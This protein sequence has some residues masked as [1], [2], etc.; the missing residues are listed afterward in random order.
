MLRRD[1]A[2][3]R[4]EVRIRIRSR[5]TRMR[6]RKPGMRAV[7][8]V[9]AEQDTPH[10]RAGSRYIGIEVVRKVGRR[11]CAYL[12]RHDVAVFAYHHALN[13]PLFSRQF[14]AHVVV[15]I[16]TVLELGRV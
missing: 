7:I 4:A 10:S 11:T 13:V 12:H 8:R 1:K 3:P 14:S 15:V 16:T 2:K 6:I 9:T 5:V